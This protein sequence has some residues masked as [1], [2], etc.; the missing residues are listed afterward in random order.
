MSNVGAQTP[1]SAPPDAALVHGVSHR[2]ISRIEATGP[3]AMREGDHRKSR[4]R[5]LQR[6]DKTEGPYGDIAAD[7]HD[8][9]F[10]RARGEH[11]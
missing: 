7:H 10:S 5:H 2:H 1:S 3:A 4:L 8:F 9:A 11:V 6:S